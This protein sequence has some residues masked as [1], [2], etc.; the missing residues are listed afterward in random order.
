MSNAIP[1][2]HYSQLGEQTINRIAN[3][4]IEFMNFMKYFGRVF[5]HP[6]SV[7][8]EFYA[9]RPEAQFIAS[10]TQWKTAGFQL[11]PAS[12]GIQFLDN[13]GKAITL[14]DFDDVIGEYPPKRWTIT[15]KNVD[16]V[17]EKL[18]LPKNEPF[19]AAL[20]TSSAS[21]PHTGSTLSFHA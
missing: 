15:N 7:A 18:E 11:K 2:G 4:D 1:V 19:F 8:L 16:A 21:A 14:Y 9:N 3:D 13:S 10:A 12:K 6:V 5:K 17:R 20:D